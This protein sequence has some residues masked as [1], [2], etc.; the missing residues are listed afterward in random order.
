MMTST[1]PA[2]QKIPQTDFMLRQVPFCPV[3][4]DFVDISEY[5]HGKI[6]VDMQYYKMSINGA[7]NRAFV[8]KTVGDMLIKAQSMLPEGYRLKIWDAWRPYDVQ[9]SIYDIYFNSLKN[10]E[11]YRYFSDDELHE[12]ARQFVSYPDKNKNPS[13]V[14]SSGGAV[15]L[16]VTDE[17]GNELNMGTGFDDF[18]ERAYTA[19]F[20][21]SCENEAV[22]NNRRILHSVMEQCGFKNYA[23]EWWHYDYGDTF[24]GSITDE[25][26][27]YGSV[28][29]IDEL[30]VADK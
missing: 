27:K 18:S 11:K 17:N 14:H 13:F 25:S 19:F 28:F 20:E 8:R 3:D 22:K 26:V 1:E 5:S 16:T 4:E 6:L 24:F 9:K 23:Y 12:M 2:K 10:D 7:V 30:K 15:D 29:D 21:K